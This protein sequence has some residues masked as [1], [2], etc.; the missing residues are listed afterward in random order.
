MKLTI[1]S[2]EGNQFRYTLEAGGLKIHARG[3]IDDPIEFSD[4]QVEIQGSFVATSQEFGVLQHRRH[5]NHT[6]EE[7]TNPHE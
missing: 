5:D 7:L 3:E 6:L 2:I 4:E 1:H